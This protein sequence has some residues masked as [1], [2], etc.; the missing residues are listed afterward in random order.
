MQSDFIC[1]ECPIECDEESLFC[2]FRWA[3]NPNAAQRAVA[4]T[5]PE[6]QRKRV[7]IDPEERFEMK[8]DILAILRSLNEQ[9]EVFSS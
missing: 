3:T 9:R 5:Q 8:R 7:Q 6:P 4:M 1:L 2:A